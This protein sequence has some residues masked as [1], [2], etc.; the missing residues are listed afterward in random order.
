MNN[1][2]TIE[3]ALNIVGQHLDAELNAM[4]KVRAE[5]CVKNNCS[6]GEYYEY[7]NKEIIKLESLMLLLGGLIEDVTGRPLDA[8]FWNAEFRRNPKMD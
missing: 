4:K 2:A 6:I 1:N 5:W 7:A 3:A 8:N